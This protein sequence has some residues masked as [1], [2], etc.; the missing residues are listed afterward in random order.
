MNP[1]VGQ[2]F[3]ALTLVLAGPAF[4]NTDASAVGLWRSTGSPDTAAMLEL[5]AGGRFRFML[6]EGALDERAE[7]V[8]TGDGPMLMLTSRPRPVRP[9][10]T[11]APTAPSCDR[12]FCLIVETP[13][14]QGVAGIDFRI[15][16]KTGEPIE[17]YTQYDGWGTDRFDHAPATI[18]LAEPVCGI[19]SQPVPI[20]LGVRSMRF[21]LTP[22]DLGIADFDGVSATMDADVLTLEHRLHPIRFRRE[23][24]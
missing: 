20:A 13:E 19:V 18:Q 24:R 9:T 17:G 14:G 6:A 15:E 4:A 3:A 22:N 1:A 23:G 21:I 10:I 16:G 7:G 12:A 2:L 5:S 8:W 11:L